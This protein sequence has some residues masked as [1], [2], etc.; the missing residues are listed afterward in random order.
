MAGSARHAQ[1]STSPLPAIRI[2][3]PHPLPNFATSAS[4]VLSFSGVVRYDPII[5]STKIS[6]PL[7]LPILGA[8]LRPAPTKRTNFLANTV[9]IRTVELSQ[10]ALLRTRPLEICSGCHHLRISPALAPGRCCRDETKKIHAIS[11]RNCREISAKRHAKN[12]KDV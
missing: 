3:A 5:V 2:F 9:I 11:A 6:V 8:G 1:N 7:K 10:R 4:G 12:K